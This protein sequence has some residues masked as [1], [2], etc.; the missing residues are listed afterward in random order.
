MHDAAN[1]HNE[2]LDEHEKGINDANDSD[3][4]VEMKRRKQRKRNNQKSLLFLSDDD[5]DEKNEARR[6][7]LEEHKGDAVLMATQEQFSE[8]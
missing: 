5:D 1:D 2:G 3:D 7:K 4:C 6:R 8:A